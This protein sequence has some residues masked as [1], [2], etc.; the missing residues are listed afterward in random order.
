MDHKAHHGDD[1]HTTASTTASTTGQQ[2]G[3]APRASTTGQHQGASTAGQHG[4]NAGH[5]ARSPSAPTQIAR[6]PA[7][8]A[9]QAQT[10][11]GQQFRAGGQP[12]GQVIKEGVLSTARG[13]EHAT[14]RQGMVNACE[15]P[16][17]DVSRLRQRA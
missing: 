9:R 16:D 14:C 12:P 15:P 2:N 1:G 11:E 5:D 17:L 3:P 7:R 6:L 10:E 4:H 13:A 8:P